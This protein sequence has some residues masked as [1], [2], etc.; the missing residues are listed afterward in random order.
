MDIGTRIARLRK[1]HDLNQKEL[2]HKLNI[3]TTTLS[4]YENNHREPP[5]DVLKDIT[6][7]FNISIDFLIEDDKIIPIDVGSH[8]EVY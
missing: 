7:I 2:A 5:L 3:P 1:L 4:G 6:N 8:D